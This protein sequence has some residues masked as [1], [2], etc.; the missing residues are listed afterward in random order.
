MWY[1]MT[2]N[3]VTKDYIHR[4]A[5]NETK[6]VPPFLINRAENI[7]SDKYLNQ[8]YGTRSQ[9][10]LPQFKGNFVQWQ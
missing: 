7:D 6:S 2:S 1:A 3:L 4:G 10:R 8:M 5:K 9:L